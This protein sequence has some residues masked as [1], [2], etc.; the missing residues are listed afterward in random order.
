MRTPDWPAPGGNLHEL[1]YETLFAYNIVTGS[2]DPLLAK[3]LALP[4]AT[5]ITFALQDGTHWQD[6]EALTADDVLYTFGLYKNYSNLRYSTC[7][8]IS[9]TSVSQMIAAWC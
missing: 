3:D 7:G 8:T 2:L 4:D 1:V 6:G 9:P 5:T